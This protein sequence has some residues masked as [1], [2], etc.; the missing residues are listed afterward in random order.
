VLGSEKK[1]NNS[2]YV[3]GNAEYLSKYF[4]D[5]KFD[6]IFSASTFRHFIDP[7]GSLIEAYSLLK[8]GGVLMIDE[9][10]LFGCDGHL[11][12]LY[13][14]LKNA[15]YKIQVTIPLNSSRDNSFYRNVIIQK[16]EDKP[17]LIIPLSFAGSYS[18]PSS[19]HPGMMS[20]AEYTP[21]SC[22]QELTSVSEEAN[23]AFMSGK[24]IIV[25]LLP[26]EYQDLL[27]TCQ[28]L[29]DLVRDGNYL[30]QSPNMKYCMFVAKAGE[31][32]KSLAGT[33]EVAAKIQCAATYFQQLNMFSHLLFSITHDPWLESDDSKKALINLVV[34][35]ALISIGENAEMKKFINEVGLPFRGRHSEEGLMPAFDS[36]IERLY[37]SSL[38]QRNSL[39]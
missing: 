29:G 28:T 39:K 27:S 26:R 35:R 34:A 36:F 13:A 38:T 1:P 11:Q 20:K 19:V 24:K 22:L 3:L 15:G 21:D 10:A 14:Y 6:Y 18:S 30:K 31:E 9:L 12:S 33:I 8:P 4:P 16:N 23:A 17:N 25:E 7:V 5:Q 32:I 37:P 2:Q